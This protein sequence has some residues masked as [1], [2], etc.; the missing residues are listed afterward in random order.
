MMNGWPRPRK[1]AA[2]GLGGPHWRKACEGT[3]QAAAPTRQTA[4]AG[5]AGRHAA[6]TVIVVDT[7]VFVDYFN[8]T[9][10]SETALLDGILGNEP[11]VIGDLILAEV[12][13]AFRGQ[14]DVRRATAAFGTLVFTPMVGCEIT[15][16]SARCY[17][18]RPA[19][20]V[21]VRKTVDM[22]VA[23]ICLAQGYS[24]LHSDRDCGSIA[25]HLGLETL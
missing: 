5:P 11:V 10:T 24:L 16:A 12:L 17:R 8:G 3:G 14:Q 18:S 13:Q 21:T 4:L 23:T 19:K 20:G 15:L 9:E 25:E 1:Q 6:R 7:S 22:L 2:S